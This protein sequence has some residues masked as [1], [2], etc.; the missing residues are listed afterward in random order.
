MASDETRL[1]QSGQAQ[2]PLCPRCHK[3]DLVKTSLEA[4]RGGIARLA[5]PPMPA[6]Q[7]PMINLVGPAVVLVGLAIFFIFVVLG[8]TVV[9]DIGG[10]ALI[11]QVIVTLVIIV[12]A[13]FVSF[14]AFQRVVRSDAE[15]TQRYPAWDRAMEHWRRLY[16]CARDDLIFDG[17]Q[18]KVVSEEALKTLLRVE[19]EPLPGARQSSSAAAPSHS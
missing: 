15:V 14:I 8:E 6:R 9:G 5:P 11:A 16:Y 10:P 2:K 1:P 3:V 18:G 7:T 13:L 4:Y 17:Q 12:A 19:P